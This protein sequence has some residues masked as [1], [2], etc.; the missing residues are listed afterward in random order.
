MISLLGIEGRMA[1]DQALNKQ[2]VFMQIDQKCIRR[3]LPDALNLV[4]WH[5]CK[6]ERGGT[7]RAKGMPRDLV[8]RKNGADTIHKPRACRNGSVAVQPELWEMWKTGVA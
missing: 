3:P 1:S 6:H 7:T 2:W 8:G 4:Q 5:A